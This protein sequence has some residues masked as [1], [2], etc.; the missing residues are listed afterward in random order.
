MS[1]KED[2]HMKDTQNDDGW[3]DN[4]EA[5]EDNE[6]GGEDG[7]EDDNP[8]D[9][10]GATDVTIARTENL[11]VTT[12]TRSQS[13]LGL[14]KSEIDLAIQKRVQ[15]LK[16]QI[17]LDGEELEQKKKG[18]EIICIFFFSN[19]KLQNQKIK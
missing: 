4:D 5:I 10:W 2:V 15:Q 14:S 3:G 13:V 17:E 7:W 6:D 9:D 18:V 12:L 19:Y 11:E 16:D 1:D 8:G